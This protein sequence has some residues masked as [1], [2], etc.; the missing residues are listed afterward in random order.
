MAS[1]EI[2]GVIRGSWSRESCDP[3]DLA[4]WSH[5]NPARGQCGVTALVVQDL[6]GGELL[7]AEVHH[8]D[9]RRQG[10]HYWNRIGGAELDLTREQFRDGEVIGPP[11]VVE[12]PAPPFTGRLE[13]QYRALSAAVLA[14][15]AG[16]R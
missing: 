6:L 12:R 11:Q 15:Y 16:A 2:E 9:G 13:A 10:V 3:V 8:A 14:R 7:V 4:D 5:E 1:V